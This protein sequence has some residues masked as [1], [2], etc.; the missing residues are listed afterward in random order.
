MQKCIWCNYVLA[1]DWMKWETPGNP[2]RRAKIW[3]Q[4]LLC[5]NADD[6]SPTTMLGAPNMEMEKAR[7]GWTTSSK[8]HAREGKRKL[9]STDAFSQP[10]SIPPNSHCIWARLPKSPTGWQSVHFKLRV[11]FSM[12]LPNMFVERIIKQTFF[13]VSRSLNRRLTQ[14]YSNKN[15]E[16]SY[17]FRSHG[18]HGRILTAYHSICR[19]QL[20]FLQPATHHLYEHFTYPQQNI[21]KTKDC[22]T[23][24]IIKSKMPNSELWRSCRK[25]PI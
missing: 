12:L 14:V 2:F 7:H 15:S 11:F 9:G 20:E 18:L 21:T 4:H 17:L 25:W 10:Q 3:N 22:S 1:Y 24:Y 8:A 6:C 16:T 13:W 19:H 23:T 5:T